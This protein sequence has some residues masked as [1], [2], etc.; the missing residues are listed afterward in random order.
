MSGWRTVTLR[1]PKIHPSM[2]RNS[3]PCFMCLKGSEVS[4]WQWDCGGKGVQRAWGLRQQGESVESSL[5]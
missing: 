2:G 3:S 4:V 5:R 1:A